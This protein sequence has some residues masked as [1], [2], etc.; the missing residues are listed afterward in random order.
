MTE[1][2]VRTRFAPS[3]TGYMHIGGMRTALFNWLFAR[4]HRGRF[5]LRIDDT[6]RD[7]N[8]EQAL[9]PILHAFRW[10]GLDWDEGPDVGGEFG[11][12][13]Q[14]Q[15]TQFYREAADKLLAGGQAFKDFDPPEM[16]RADREAAEAERRNYLNVRRS[17]DLSDAE[18]QQYEEEKRPFVVR[19]LVPRDRTVAIDDA[20]RGRVEWDCSIIP[21]PVI[22]RGNG[23]PL[24]NFA[25]VVDDARLQIS[26][27]IRA[28]EHLTNT[29][30]QVLIHEALGNVLPVFAHIPFVAAP[31][32]KKKLSKREKDLE[33]YRRNPQFKRLFDLGDARLPR[34]GLEMSARLNPVMVDFYERVGYLPEAILN[35][36]SRLGWSLDDRTEILPL[37]MVVENFSL[38]RVVKSPAGLDPDKLDSYQLHWMGRLSRDEKIAGCLPYLRKAGMIRENVDEAIR[39]YVGR[40]I[41][42]LEDRLKIFSDILDYDEYFVDDDALRYD[43]KAFD[44]RLTNAPESLDLLRQ[45]RDVLADVEPFDVEQTETSLKA[46]VE[47]RDVKLGSIIHALRVAVTGK[48]KGPGMFD[49]LALLGK[50]RCLARI[51]RATSRP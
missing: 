11:P 48:A 50:Q 7:R 42:I 5:I 38:E 24:Y 3:P 37:E 25:T 18:R 34:I 47:R 10:L 35:A 4:R 9:G 8:V 39:E 22:L 26:H 31:G 41:A 15:R 29:A 14:S 36:L 19:F 12:Y 16:S 21:D 13:F 20:V 40:L 23:A 2:P 1:R 51:D 30:V 43:E 17:L 27:V 28:E 49:C 45:Y 33:R 46:F 32:G 44:K 6:D